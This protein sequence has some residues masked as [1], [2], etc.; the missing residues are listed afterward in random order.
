MRLHFVPSAGM[1]FLFGLV[2]T[3][4]LQRNLHAAL[5]TLKDITTDATDPTNLADT[6]PSIAVDRF[7]PQRIAVVA[8]SGS[9]TAAVGAPVWKSDDGGLTW[10]KVNQLPRPAGISSLPNDQKI[11]FDAQGR[12]FVAALGITP[13]NVIRCYIF[14]QTGVYDANLTPGQAYGDDQ[15]Q[16]DI[17]ASPT[18]YLIGRLF[19]P[20]L[21]FAGVRQRSSVAY[22]SDGGITMTEVGVGDNSVFN[23]RTT[24]SAISPYGPA[25]I[26]YKTREGATADPNFEFAHFR[27]HRS[28]DG[29]ATWN[30]LGPSG[31]SVH[32]VAQVQTWF[33]TTWGSGPKLARARSS[34]A[35][36]AAH[37]G[38]ADVYVAYTHRD[39]SGFGQVFVARSINL[40]STWT[41]TRV[42]DGT[43]HSAF[44][45]IAVAG[46][47]AVGVLYVDHDGAGVYRQRFARS[48][49][50]GATWSE[51]T[52]QSFN[53]ATIP[54]A[55]DG[56]LWGDYQGLTAV[57]ATFYG[58]FTGQSI[59]R[60]ITQF[61]PIFFTQ[62]ATP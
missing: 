62:S 6:E 57:G 53:P 9:S 8:F 18:S 43:R 58:V 54:N 51:E 60:T 22:S 14:R 46:N 19:S 26:V 48:F 25:F 4:S 32:G 38:D 52:L 1:L 36:I 5:A 21:S 2:L 59:G 23:N 30:A 7:N 15:P 20:F 24:R 31:V 49:N 45:N 17:D 13:T 56:F 12:L 42:T 37:T 40:G 10:R 28:D 33:T 44:P 61:D 41:L 35:W 11:A 27:V 55:Q 34:D 50:Q 39:A 47:G 3:P 16:L 29:G